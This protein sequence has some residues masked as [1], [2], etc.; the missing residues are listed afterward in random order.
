MQK[1]TEEFL[2]ECCE[3][4]TKAKEI[5]GNKELMKELEPYMKEKGK[6]MMEIPGDMRQKFQAKLNEKAKESDESSKG[7]EIVGK[8]PKIQGKY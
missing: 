1:Y 5:E 4:M 3:T 2:D 7:E 6:S 8:K